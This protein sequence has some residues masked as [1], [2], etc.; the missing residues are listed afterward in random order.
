M[1][2]G[3]AVAKGADD[4]EPVDED[5]G[6]DEGTLLGV[7][8][9]DALGTDNANHLELML[10]RG[11][12]PMK[13][14]RRSESTRCLGSRWCVRLCPRLCVPTRL[15]ARSSCGRRREHRALVRGYGRSINARSGLLQWL[16]EAME[17]VF[18]ASAPPCGLPREQGVTF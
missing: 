5:G 17:Q 13:A 15:P 1:D 18:R 10:A 14:R 11:F 7:T 2:D 4:G 12:E 6:V 8:D 9:G 16:S 3:N